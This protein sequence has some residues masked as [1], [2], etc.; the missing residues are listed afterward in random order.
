MCKSQSKFGQFGIQKSNRT[1]KMGWREY[2]LIFWVVINGRYHLNIKINDVKLTTDVQR[3]DEY[4]Q[5]QEVGY[6]YKQEKCPIGVDI[7]LHNLYIFFN[8]DMYL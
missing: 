5:H 6:I 3:F 8:Y 4:S 7:F 2:V 1:L